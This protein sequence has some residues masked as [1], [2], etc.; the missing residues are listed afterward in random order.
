MLRVESDK[1]DP[2]A[3]AERVH[4]MTR[5]LRSFLDMAQPRSIINIEKMADAVMQTYAEKD[6]QV[7][8]GNG[9]DEI[10]PNYCQEQE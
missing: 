2:I 4:G 1:P 6:M 7:Q 3:L 5:I 9:L 8:N 10:L